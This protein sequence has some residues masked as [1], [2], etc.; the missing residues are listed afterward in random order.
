MG[1]PVRGSN[2]SVLK[3]HI[4][5]GERLHAHISSACGET[6]TLRAVCPYRLLRPS[7]G[8]LKH[9]EANSA[10]QHTH[11]PHTT[12]ADTAQRRRKKLTQAHTRSV[13]I[14]TSQQAAKVLRSSR[15]W[16]SQVVSLPSLSPPAS[17]P[18][19]GRTKA[20]CSA[21]MNPNPLVAESRPR[22]QRSPC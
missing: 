21:D 17:G 11:T 10:L 9:N 20:L 19:L 3:I 8:S 15:A 1:A 12:S 16:R 22:S 18:G 13:R 2:R 14:N 5:H 6:D 4:V 7:T